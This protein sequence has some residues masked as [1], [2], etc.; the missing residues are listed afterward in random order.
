MHANLKNFVERSPREVWLLGQAI[1]GVASTRLGLWVLPLAKIRRLIWRLFSAGHPLPAIHRCSQ[2]QVIRAV[3]SAAIHC[4]ISTTCLATAVVGQALLHRHG[5][6]AQ[7]RFG[8]RRD[9]KGS[10]SA[11]AWLEREGTVV[12]GGPSTV[13]QSYTRLPEMEHLI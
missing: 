6:K 5:Y 13:V 11:H 4:P 9:A 7:L 2:D 3:V 1:L 8:V 12:L 10:F